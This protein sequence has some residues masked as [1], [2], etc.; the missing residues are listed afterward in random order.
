MRLPLMLPGF[1]SRRRGFSP[2]ASVFP[3][4]QQPTFPNSNST[5]NQV[6]EEVNY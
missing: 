1:E 3:S 2:G 5:K 6:D 4:R